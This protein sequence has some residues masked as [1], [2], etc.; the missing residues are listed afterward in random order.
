MGWALVPTTWFTNEYKRHLNDTYT[1]TLI[2]NFNLERHITDSNKLLYKL[3]SRFNAHI[4][5]DKR[6]LLNPT[7]ILTTFKYLTWNCYLKYT[8][9]Q[10]LLL[11]VT[12]IF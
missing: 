5:P 3:K 8:N 7:D 6:K 9:S 12:S 11:L 1:Y 4:T 10:Q 2:D